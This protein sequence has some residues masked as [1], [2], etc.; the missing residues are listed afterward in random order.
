MPSL[1]CTAPQFAPARSWQLGVGP[2]AH[3]GRCWNRAQVTQ[4]Q[5]GCRCSTS[6]KPSL[7]PQPVSQADEMSTLPDLQAKAM[8]TVHVA[9][10]PPLAKPGYCAFSMRL[11]LAT[12]GLIEEVHAGQELGHGQLPL[13]PSHHS[14]NV[15]EHVLG[16]ARLHEGAEAVSPLSKTRIALVVLCCLSAVLRK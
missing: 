3:N 1:I 7:A 16:Q 13:V 12:L 4:G 2:D 9:Q 15:L 6:M 8:Q 14:P 10:A 11:H 5:P